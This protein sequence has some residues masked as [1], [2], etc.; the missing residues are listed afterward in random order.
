MA[1]HDYKYS[2]DLPEE[3]SMLPVMVETASPLTFIYKDAKGKRTRRTITPYGWALT[4]EPTGL[5]FHGM[6]HLRKARRT[7]HANRV[8]KVI[9]TKTEEKII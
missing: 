8:I 7:F 3:L 1:G 4:P 6:C 5:T 9:Q 2:D